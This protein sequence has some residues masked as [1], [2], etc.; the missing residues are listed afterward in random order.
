MLLE[1]FTIL[2]CKSLSRKGLS[3]KQMP[4]F[5]IYSSGGHFVQ[6]SQTSWQYAQLRMVLI[7]PVKFH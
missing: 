5:F 6:Q 2:Q 1:T 3:Q 4:G 7:T